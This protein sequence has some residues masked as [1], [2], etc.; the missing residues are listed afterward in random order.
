MTTAGGATSTI[1][2]SLSQWRTTAEENR[3]KRGMA[4]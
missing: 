3:Q 4:S 1:G 2:G